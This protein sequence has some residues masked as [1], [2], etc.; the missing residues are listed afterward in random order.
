[1]LY[2]D[3]KKDIINPKRC[4]SMCLKAGRE[5]FFCHFPLRIQDFSLYTLS[6]SFVT[7]R[8]WP[9]SAKG[10]W[11]ESS[12]FLAGVEILKYGATTSDLPTE[13]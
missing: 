10:S 6:T 4:Q 12:Y 2:Y 3:Q 5:K 13:F 7:D 1:M 11:D 8:D 9:V